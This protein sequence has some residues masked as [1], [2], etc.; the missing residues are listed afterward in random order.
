MDFYQ[1]LE[2][3]LEYSF[4]NKDFYEAKQDFIIDTNNRLIHSLYIPNQDKVYVRVKVVHPLTG[5]YSLGE[6]HEFK[7]TK[8]TYFEYFNVVYM[9]HIKKTRDIIS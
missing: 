4:N 7:I 3:V 6:V 8:S 9:K 5:K 2:Y 1:N